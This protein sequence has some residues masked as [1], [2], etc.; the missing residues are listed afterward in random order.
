MI[1]VVKGAGSGGCG[2][3]LVLGHMQIENIL[4]ALTKQDKLKEN[5]TFP[6]Q[7]FLFG[8]YF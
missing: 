3:R 5:Q 6:W 1:L 2:G 8:K 4:R 7:R